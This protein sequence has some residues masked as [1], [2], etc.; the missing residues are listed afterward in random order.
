MSFLDKLK[1][2]LIDSGTDSHSKDIL[3]SIVKNLDVIAEDSPQLRSIR[4][5]CRSGLISHE[6]Y[7]EKCLD[8][9]AKAFIDMT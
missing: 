1:G 6:Q 9:I 3:E 5:D 8:L 2:A 7:E 4:A